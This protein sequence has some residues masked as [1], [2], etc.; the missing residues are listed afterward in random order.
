MSLTML[1]EALLQYSQILKLDTVDPSDLQ[2]FRRWLEKPLGGHG[3]LN[4]FESDTWGDEDFREYVNLYNGLEEKDRFTL[5]L[6]NTFVRWWHRRWWHRK[7][8][9]ILPARQ[10]VIEVD[11]HPR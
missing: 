7:A 10:G 3:F 5:W 2:F 8:V 6:R 9:G 4:S 11:S 1:D